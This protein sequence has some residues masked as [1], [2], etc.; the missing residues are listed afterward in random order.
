MADH[1][2]ERLGQD[3][4]AA[5]WCS[6]EIES[7]CETGGDEQRM[8]QLDGSTGEVQRPRGGG[9]RRGRLK[10][11][12]VFVNGHKQKFSQGGARGVGGKR[13]RGR[14]RK[15]LEPS[16]ILEKQENFDLTQVMD[17]ISD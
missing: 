6:S 1:I 5:A 9:Q 13:K 16:R 8:L 14:P 4:R 2:F 3:E 10:K 12:S 15:N 7:E 17:L 11:L